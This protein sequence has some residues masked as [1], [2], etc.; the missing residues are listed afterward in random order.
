MHVEE[1]S[2]PTLG[3]LA[4]VA[5]EA[6][7]V[8]ASSLVLE[9]IYQHCAELLPGSL[10]ETIGG[11]ARA[12]QVSA[13]ALLG[14]AERLERRLEAPAQEPQLCAR[15]EQVN[16]PI[17]AKGLPADLPSSSSPPAPPAELDQVDDELYQVD[18]E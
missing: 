16:C 17:C 10:R 1:E 14:V 4:I 7:N 3:D 11:L 2:P 9:A 6:A 13:S 8:K 5:N 15:H 18:D 12:A